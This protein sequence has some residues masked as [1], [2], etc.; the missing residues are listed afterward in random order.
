MSKKIKKT[1]IV[2]TIFLIL[3]FIS[4]VSAWKNGSYGY[5]LTQ[6]DITTDYG[7]HDWIAD[8]AIES[9]FASNSTEWQWLKDRKTLAYIG[10]EAPDNSGVSMTLDGVAI[11]GFG[12]TTQHHV[13]FNIDGTVKEENS[14]LRAKWCGDWANVYIGQNKLDAAAFYIGA[15]THYIADLGV[16]A[17]VVENNIAPD[18]LDFDLYH[19][20]LEGYVGTRTNEYD[21]FN[22]FFNNGTYVINPQKPYN[23]S[24]DVAWDSYKDPTPTESTTRDAV[25]LHSNKETVGTWAL[26]LAA[27]SGE[28]ALEQLYYDRFEECLHNA[29][30]G[31]IN[32]IAYVSGIS[33][34]S[35]ITS[36]S[37]STTTSDSL[38]D[39]GI[40][41]FV[42]LPMF[43]I[44]SVMMLAIIIRRKQK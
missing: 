9:L 4:S 13:Y 24:V 25:W 21:D 35:T 20:T 6:Y 23:I 42:Y 43:C 34:N 41:G 16:F 37:S 22:E 2:F 1:S 10:T 11:T 38:D 17:H 40:D 19:S 12:D 18:N 15:M 8:A 29:I 39:L 7:T 28:S 31:S 14:A 44:L 27:R 26:S 36:T 30:Q 3:P 5:D 33:S 32:A